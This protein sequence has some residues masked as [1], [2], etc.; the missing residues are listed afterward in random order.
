MYKKG[1]GEMGGIWMDSEDGRKRKN[2]GFFPDPSLL[3]FI[4]SNI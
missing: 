2:K 4:N 3:Y 1:C